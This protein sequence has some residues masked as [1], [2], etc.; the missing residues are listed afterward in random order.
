MKVG[1]LLLAAGRSNRFGS[2]KRF[3]LLENGKTVLETTLAAIVKSGLPVM[4]CLAPQDEHGVRLC[5]QAQV[6][7]IECH[8]APMGMG[9]TLAEGVSG[10]PGWNGVLIALADMPWIVPATY[11]QLA[12][13]LSVNHI[14]RPMFSGR[15]GNPVGFG[16]KYFKELSVLCGDTGARSLVVEHTD[17]V[18]NVDCSDPGVLRDVDIPGDIV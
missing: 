3:A 13:A 10:L 18:I 11:G 8:S 9:S 5:K 12:E 14:A 15:A 2:D 4:V 7:Y 16:G 17:S 6:S 1:V